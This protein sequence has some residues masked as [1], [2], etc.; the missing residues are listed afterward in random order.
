MIPVWILFFF[1]P[2]K[3]KNTN[4]HI[5]LHTYINK[6]QKQTAPKKQM[7]C[8]LPISLSLTLSFK[9][10]A[11]SLEV[12]VPKMASIDFESYRWRAAYCTHE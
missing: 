2:L 3:K 7:L 11:I 10:N 6:K 12:P 4:K 1:V 8:M 5:I 9:Q